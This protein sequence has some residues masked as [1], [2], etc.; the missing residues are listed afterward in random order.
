MCLGCR[1]EALENLR[2]VAIAAAA[3]REQLLFVAS[4][5]SAMGQAPRDASRD[6]DYDHQCLMQLQ[7]Y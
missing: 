4:R 5:R 7:E 6:R 2:W 3:Q 1:H